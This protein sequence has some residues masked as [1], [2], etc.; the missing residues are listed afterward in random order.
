MTLSVKV[1]SCQL[2]QAR[3]GA[4]VNHEGQDADAVSPAPYLAPGKILGFL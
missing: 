2:V 3:A 1:G 4:P